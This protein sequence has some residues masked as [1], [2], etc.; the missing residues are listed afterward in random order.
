VEAAKPLFLMIIE[1]RNH[2]KSFSKR[3]KKLPEKCFIYLFAHMSSIQAK[4]RDISDQNK[5]NILV[6][7]TKM[8]TK[9]DI[10]NKKHKVLKKRK[11]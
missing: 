9:L 1:N 6:V 11:F 8:K 2:R 4:Y 10:S 5:R 7:K 3:G